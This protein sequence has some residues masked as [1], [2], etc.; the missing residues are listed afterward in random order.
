MNKSELIAKIAEAQGLTKKDATKAVDGF[1]AAV[2]EVLTDGENVT[3]QGFGTFRVADHKEKAGT[4]PK[5]GKPMKIAATKRASFSAG[6]RLKDA[7]K[8]SGI[9]TGG[10]GPGG[11]G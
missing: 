8:K 9:K 6:T 5:T 11:K 10:G 7:V 1:V 2:Q 4:N 3:I